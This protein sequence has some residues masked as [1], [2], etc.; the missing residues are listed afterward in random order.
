MISDWNS[1]GAVVLLPKVTVLIPT[2]NR[3]PYLSDAIWS[4]LGQIYKNFE[5]IV[6]DDGSTDNTCQ[7]IYSIHDHR[8]RYLHQ[9][10]R[11]ISAA[12]NAGIRLA[13]GLYIARL[14]SDDLWL[15]HMLETLVPVLD[16]M[17][18]VG[19]VY[20]KGQAMDNRGRRLAHIQGRGE[21]FPGDILRSLA[22]DDCTCN[23]ALVARRVCFDRVG[24][25]DEALI[26]NEDWDMWLRV[27]RHYRFAFV[28][29]V[30]ACIR[31]HNDNLTGLASAHFGTVLDTRTE[32]L[33]KLFSDPGLP[34]D[35][36]AMKSIAYTNVYLFQGR[37]WLQVRNLRNAG[38]AFSLALQ[39]SDQYLI[40]VVRIVWFAVALPILQRYPWGQRTTEALANLRKRRQARRGA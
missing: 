4:V 35:V 13:R 36:Q 29:K 6:I 31:W 21:R 8:I 12:L 2:Y 34:S 38:R 9:S 30:V 23:I 7:L 22:Y 19:V 18:E 26:A 5:V 16:A 39:T 33:D 24:L 17:P 25:Y 32:P 20:A 10:H 15:P 28:D 3:A 1:G 11:G 14:D 37:R 27:A 40:T